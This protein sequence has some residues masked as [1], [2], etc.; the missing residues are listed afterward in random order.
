[1]ASESLTP[2]AIIRNRA[3][4]GSPTLDPDP[5]NNQAENIVQGFTTADLELSKRASADPAIIGG[6][7]IY[8]I[9]VHNAGP[10]EARGVDVKELLP[11]GLTLHSL[12][13][14][15]GTC[16]SQ[17]CQ[18]GAVPVSTTVIITAETTVNQDV[19]NGDQLCNKAV[20]FQDTHDPNTSNNSAE[21][22][23]TAQRLSDLSIVKESSSPSVVV[24]DLLTYTL[25]AKNDGPSDAVGVLV[26]DSLP[27]SVTYVS[28][29][30]SCTD[31]G[32]GK[33]RCNLGD[34]AAG[35]SK[36]FRI[37]IRVIWTPEPKSTTRP[38]WARPMASIQTPAITPMATLFS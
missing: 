14:S 32:G 30:D 20:G 37:T 24:G 25:T 33:L 5:G 6:S 7:L 19:A 1:M 12:S 23:V 22:C 36:S 28:N 15:Q 10:S 38:R 8:T 26:T 21:V 3:Q 18:L 31:L 13:A 16:V 9:E 35:A 4:A 29:S 34:L 27:V 2:S 11:P 17:I